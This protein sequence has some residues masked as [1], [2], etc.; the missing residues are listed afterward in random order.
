[1]TALVVAGAPAAVAQAQTAPP[2][3]PSADSPAGVIYQLPLDTARQDAAP[4]PGS[5]GSDGRGGG[6]AT[7]TGTGGPL[8]AIRSEN[9]FGSSSVVPGA[10]ASAKGVGEAGEYA[11]SLRAGRGGGVDGEGRRGEP[12]AG[13]SSGDSLASR[14]GSGAGS[15][16][17]FAVP[18]LVLTVLLG[19]AA[20][21]A[22]T[23]MR[24]TR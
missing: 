24:H 16:P 14:I 22:A 6:T 23:R 1:M 3:D 7:P 15:S 13:A 5:S 11:G 20:G 8:S 9:N 12:L 19:L 2:S 4:R 21:S 17:S 10:I 18:L